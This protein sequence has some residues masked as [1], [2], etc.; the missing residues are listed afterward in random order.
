MVAQNYESSGTTTTKGI[1]VV[2]PLILS[3]VNTLSV[4]DTT[5]EALPEMVYP[6]IKEG[7]VCSLQ[8]KLTENTA[9]LKINVNEPV[10]STTGIMIF[11]LIEDKQSE[12]TNTNS[13]GIPNTNQ[14]KHNE[15]EPD[16]QCPV[17]DQQTSY[18]SKD[19]SS[20]GSDV[21]Q[22]GSICS[23][24]EGDTSYDSQI[25]EIFNLLLCKS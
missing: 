17:S 22:I 18:I 25:A 7:S 1:A 21:L 12:S 24:V 23:L 16:I 5:S 10:T 6:V 15:S 19:S 4:K 8:N 3:D 13:E 11:P 2:S 9:A 20:V 14:G